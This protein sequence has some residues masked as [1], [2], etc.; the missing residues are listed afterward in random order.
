MHRTNI[1]VAVS[2][3][4]I[5]LSGFLVCPTIRGDDQPA[6]PDTNNPDWI[7]LGESAGDDQ[8]VLFR[9]QFRTPPGRISGAKLYASCDNAM[10][11]WVNGT[12]VLKH[13]SWESPAFKDIAE[14]VTRGQNVIVVRGRNAGGAAGL[15]AKLVIET[16]RGDGEFEIVTDTDWKVNSAQPEGFQQLDFDDSD[17]ESATK[18]ADIGDGPWTQI[19]TATLAA[20]VALREPQA[21]PIEL[22]TVKD[23]FH[24]ELLYS[25]P[26]D[27]QGSWVNMCTLPDGRLI[28]SDQY[29][30]LFR[31]T[32]PGLGEPLTRR[33]ENSIRGIGAALRTEG[34]RLIVSQ[35]IAGGA[36]DRDGRLKSADEIIAITVDDGESQ[37]T[38]GVE[39]VDVVKWIRNAEQVRL[40]VEHEGSN[41]P[42]EIELTPQ[43]ITIVDDGADAEADTLVESL[44]LDI[45]EAQGLLWAFDSLYIVV[46]RGGKYDSGLYR[47]TDTDDDGELDQVELLRKLDGGGEHGPHAVLLSPDGE[48]L[49]IVCG[50]STKL[51]EFASSRVPQVWDEDI[52]LPRPY[53]RGFM[54]G[55]P[56]PGGF[57]AKTDPDGQTWELVSTG[58][59]NQFDAAFNR[60]GELFAYDADMEW[61]VNT[62]WYRPTRINHV[63]SGSEWGW[64]NGGGEVAHVLQ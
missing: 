20:A 7:W 53:G 14:F 13:G 61:D 58:F 33:G 27:Q 37:I 24:V 36:A 47:A 52:L 42:E 59:R 62:P 28:V 11:V 18:V 51:T 39:L 55:V 56:A 32:P 10:T 16:D 4:L 2:S 26:K 44:N 43:T 25:V 1:F 8:T 3:L 15:V 19:T 45:G 35:I 46:N 29:G 38:A 48:S 41:E 12:E 63:T 21:T 23:G 6:G 50:D 54:R 34:A 30:G 5:V 57:I 49:Y 17:W 40:L 22:L 31:V 64:R 9:R 60:D